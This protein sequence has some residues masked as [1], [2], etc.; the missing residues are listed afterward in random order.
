VKRPDLPEN[1]RVTVATG[2]RWY[3][4]G[5]KV[6]RIV[7]YWDGDRMTYADAM[8]TIVAWQS[9]GPDMP[10]FPDV[11]PPAQRWYSEGWL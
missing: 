5:R 1:M 8:T 10:V 2:R 9:R 7:Y 3:L 6:G 4:L 11:D